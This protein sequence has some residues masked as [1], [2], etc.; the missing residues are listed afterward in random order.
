MNDDASAPMLPTAPG[1]PRRGP[2]RLLGRTISKAWD[3]SIFGM[4]AQAAFWAT[5]SLPPLLLGLLGS[6][7]YVGTWFGPDTP[8]VVESKILSFCRTVFSPSVVDEIIAPTVSDVLQEGR[9]EIVSVGFLL[10]LWA[11]SSAISSFVDSIVKAHGQENLRHPV[12]QRIFALLLYAVA[13]VLA[14]FTLPL[15]A[16]GPGLLT[17]L[18]PVSWQGTADTLVH[19]FYYPGTGLLLLVGLTCLYKLA[20]PRPLPWHRLVGGAVLAG[21]FFVAASALLRI[22]LTWVTSTGYS[23]GALAAPIAYLLFTFFLGFAI[24]LGAELNATVQEM[25]PAR[26]TRLEIFRE[27][28]VEESSGTVPL[29]ARTGPMTGPLSTRVVRLG[30]RVPALRAPSTTGGPSPAASQSPPG[31]RPS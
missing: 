18:F 21:V 19:A 2:L 5:L 14:V 23:Y 11:G 8:A 1:G 31:R 25:W 17:E 20:L 4:A 6:I 10:S 22:Y 7:G 24:V 9:G 16:I 12:W 28:V 13:L 15:V 27:R 3:D 26:A 29:V 30:A